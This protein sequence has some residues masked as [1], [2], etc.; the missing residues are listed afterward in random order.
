VLAAA[1][2]AVPTLHGAEA[3][4]PAGV[5]T[6]RVRTRLPVAARPLARGAVLAESDIAWM[7]TILP[8]RPRSSVGLGLA[9]VHDAGVAPGWVT[10]RV[11]AA[12]EP[13]RRPAVEPPPAVRAGQ[14][15]EVALEQDGLRLVMYGR[16]LAEASLGERVAVRIDAARRLTGTAVAPGVVQLA[17]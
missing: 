1:F 8:R 4:A 6:G 2:G 10:R 12:G 11:V 13:L 5:D 14:E 16:A 3:Q 9:L 15:V 17:P 7:D